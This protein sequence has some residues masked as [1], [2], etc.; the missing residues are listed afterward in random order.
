M[1]GFDSVGYKDFLTF[2]IEAFRVFRRNANL[3]MNLLQLMSD[4]GIEHLSN[5][6]DA[7]LLKVQER[8]RLDLSDDAADDYLVQTINECVGAL[9]PAVLEIIHK[10][11]TDWR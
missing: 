9:F 4:A 1:G 7:T 2:S 5:N 6:V 10:L 3:I 11:A 8:F